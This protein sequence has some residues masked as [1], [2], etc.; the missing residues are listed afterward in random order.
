MALEHFRVLIHELLNKD[1]YIVPEE[2]SLV[3]LDNK[4]AICMAK[5][6][7]DTKHTRHIARRKYIV[8]N[9]EQCNMQKNYW[10]EGGLK[11]A[12]IATKNIGE[13]D[14]TPRMRYIMVR[15]DK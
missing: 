4:S 10:C 3:V 15:L 5:N 9:G 8:R 1:T 14:S 2:A 7:K 6:G 13:H 12:D 11:L